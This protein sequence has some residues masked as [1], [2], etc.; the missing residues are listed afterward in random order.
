MF[1]M[2]RVLPLVACALVTLECR[3]PESAGRVA[4]A[5]SQPGSDPQAAAVDAL[6]S[7][8][9]DADPRLRK[10]G[11]MALVAMQ[12]RA[13]AAVPHLVPLLD[14]QAADVRQSAF[15]ALAVIGTPE[16]GAIL[17]TPRGDAEGER[18]RTV[19]LAILHLAE[20]QRTQGALGHPR[21]GGAVHARRGGSLAALPAIE[22]AARHGS[23]TRSAIA[24]LGGFGLPAVPTLVELVR[25]PAGLGPAS[26]ALMRACT[27]DRVVY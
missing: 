17:A 27:E 26:H 23:Q 13:A 1:R 20:T 3:S 19:A 4:P 2:I 5:T 6:V 10:L 9:R 24:V 21:P 11:C 15:D 7:L 25:T 12:A 16:A 18:Q 14:D 8:L 22:D